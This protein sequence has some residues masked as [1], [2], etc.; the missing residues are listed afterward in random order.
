MRLATLSVL[1]LVGLTGC[2]DTETIPTPK[3]YPTSGQVIYAGK[4]AEGVYVSFVPEGGV[5]PGIKGHPTATTDAQ[6]KFRLTTLT[7]GDGAPPGVFRVV[8]IWDSA[9]T[10]EESETGGDRFKDWY[11]AKHTPLKVTIKEGTNELAPFQIPEIRTQANEVAGVPG[12]N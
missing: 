4:P 10:N 7:E 1:L 11:D 12:M 2:S 3:L 6:G 5:I 9:A 8:L